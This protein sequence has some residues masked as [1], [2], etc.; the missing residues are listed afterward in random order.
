MVKEG[1]FYCVWF[2]VY[3]KFKFFLINEFGSMIHGQYCMLVGNQERN[4]MTST[5]HNAALGSFQA[6]S[7]EK[8]KPFIKALELYL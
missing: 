3:Q 1:L 5:M 8:P 2:V 7:K 6:S 4:C